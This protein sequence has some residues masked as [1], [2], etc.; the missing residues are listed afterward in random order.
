MVDIPGLCMH[1][2]LAAAMQ[3][4]THNELSHHSLVDHDFESLSLSGR[5]RKYSKLVTC[6]ADVRLIFAWRC[7]KILKRCRPS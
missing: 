5:T 2:V 1:L 4:L 6:S 3:P 7:D